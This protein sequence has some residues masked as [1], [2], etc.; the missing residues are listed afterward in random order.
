MERK[1]SEMAE[2]GCTLPHLHGVVYA[3][4]RADSILDAEKKSIQ[5]RDLFAE[6]LGGEPDEDI[7]S[8]EFNEWNENPMAM[9][10]LEMAEE[11]G[12]LAEFEHWVGYSSPDYKICRDE[13][14]SLVGGDEEAAED[15]LKGTCPLHRLPTELKQSGK[16]KE[17][18][19]W[20]RAQAQARSPAMDIDIADIDLSETS[21]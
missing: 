4:W 3:S 5:E 20:V 8:S 6:R 1:Y 16:E 10:L 17:R 18:A 2:V 14:I 9:L 15:I 13:A 19:A 21:S 7:Y 12:S 11:L